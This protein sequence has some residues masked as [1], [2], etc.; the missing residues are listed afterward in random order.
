[1]TNDDPAY[2]LLARASG[3]LE[4]ARIVVDKGGNKNSLRT[5]VAHLIA[6]GLE[7]LMKHVLVTNGQSINDVK[8]KYGHSL[9]GLWMADEMNS[10]RKSAYANACSAWA[11]ARESKRYKGLFKEDPK[12]VL[13]EYISELGRLHGPKTGFALR[14]VSQPGETAPVPLLLLDTFQPLKDELAREYSRSDRSKQY[15]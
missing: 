11:T 7:V 3:F 12:I 15:V 1:M 9:A 10:F 14:Y 6:H 8:E 13:N 4:A 2:Q 5:P